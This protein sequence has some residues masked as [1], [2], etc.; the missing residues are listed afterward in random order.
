VLAVRDTL[1]RERAKSLR[2]QRLRWRTYRA[3]R[4]DGTTQSASLYVP[5][6]LG[7]PLPAFFNFQGLVVA[8]SI[9]RESFM[10]R[11]PVFFAPYPSP[12][13]R[14]QRC[15]LLPHYRRSS[16]RTATA[17]KHGGQEARN[18]RTDDDRFMSVAGH[19][20]A[21]PDQRR[22]KREQES[23]PAPAVR[24]AIHGLPAAGPNR[25]KKA[26]IR[27]PND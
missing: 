12:A 27:E 2:I 8:I 24:K 3:C 17:P 9:A 4:H 1:K 18:G 22:R 23:D 19:C 13:L 5:F 16:R 15:N 20:L 26:E 21:Q 25:P 7:G 10:V 14:A 11:F 6:Q